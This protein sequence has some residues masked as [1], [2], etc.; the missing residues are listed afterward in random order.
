MNGVRYH[1][2]IT[3]LSVRQMGMNH[4]QTAVVALIFSAV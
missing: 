4:D 3:A 2:F 1:D